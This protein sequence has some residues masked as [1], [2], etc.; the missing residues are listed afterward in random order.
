MV[1]ASEKL[2]L[3]LMDCTGGK[4]DAERKKY[5]VGGYPT[6][7]FLDPE[8]SK[9]GELKDR[10]PDSVVKQFEELLEKHGRAAA[11]LE[12]EK[13]VEKGK[14]EKKP[15][16]ILFVTPK[17]DSQAL[18]A[19]IGDDSLKEL[20][21]KFVFSKSDVKSDLAKTFQVAGSTQPVLFVVDP[22]LE[23]PQEKLV[24]KL[25]GKKTAKE[26]KKELEGALKKFEEGK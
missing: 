18:E 21:E 11:W 24:K 16:A 6:I 4:Y 2:M 13:A 14:D 19:A 23:K 5:G 15:V 1:K 12:W 10:S 25:T 9:V 26:L 22:K 17:S 20:R 7:V 8:G 3:V